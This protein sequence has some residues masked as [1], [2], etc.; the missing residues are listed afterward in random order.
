MML[1]IQDV[2]LLEKAKERLSNVLWGTIQINSIDHEDSTS[3]PDTGTQAIAHRIK[4]VVHRLH[5][6]VAAKIAAIAIGQIEAGKW[7]VGLT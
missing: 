2:A 4:V 3:D 1:K 7:D 6:V 5:C